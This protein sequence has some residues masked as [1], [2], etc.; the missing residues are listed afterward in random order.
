MRRSRWGLVLLLAAVVTLLASPVGSLGVRSDSNGAV[1]IAPASLLSIQCQAHVEKKLFSQPSSASTLAS[2][3]QVALADLVLPDGS[4]ELVLF[5]GHRNST[6]VV[7]AVVPGGFFAS[8]VTEVAA[9]GNFFVEFFNFSNGLTFYEEV[10]PRGRLST[11]SLPL[12]ASQT[13]VLVGS[14]TTL[15]ASQTGI[16]LAIDPSSLTIQAN[17][18]TLLPPAV[19]I[20]SVLT[21]G[22]LLY[23]GGGQTVASGGTIPF[24]GFINPL[25]KSEKT[26]S[27]SIT[28]SPTLVGHILWIGTSRGNVYFGGELETIQFSPSFLIEVL[29]GYLF[30][31]FPLTGALTNLSS[32][33]PITKLGVYSIFDVGPTVVMNLARFTLSATSFAQVSGTYVL[34]PSHHRLINDTRLTGSDFVAL[35]LESSL[36][37]GLYFVGGFNQTTGTAEIVA[38]PICLLEP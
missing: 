24:Y 34:A 3:G 37:G 26:L 32:I 1:S 20:L 4:S 6:T 25:A 7:Q 27:P 12:S 14:P 17:Y 23:V 28:T 5:D 2:V 31:F 22:G 36:S 8:L 38:V 18:S 19:L 33:D 21:V 9:G 35:Y 15:F 11:P 10:S 16:R 13:W 29:A 30:E